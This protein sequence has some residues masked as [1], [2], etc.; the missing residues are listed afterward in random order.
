MG[1]RKGDGVGDLRAVQVYPA[2]RQRARQAAAQPP[3]A[4]KNEMFLEDAIIYIY[5]CNLIVGD[6]LLISV[7]I[8]VLTKLDCQGGSCRL[9]SGCV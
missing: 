9:E 8:L 4:P 5:I 3:V 2:S 1:V 7:L 6:V